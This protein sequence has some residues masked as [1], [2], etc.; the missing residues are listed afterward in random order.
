MWTKQSQI[1]GHLAFDKRYVIVYSRGITFPKRMHTDILCYFVRKY[2][3]IVS[4]KTT[5]KHRDNPKSQ[6]ITIFTKKLP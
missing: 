6:K 5:Q 2:N 1:H 4:N 3:P